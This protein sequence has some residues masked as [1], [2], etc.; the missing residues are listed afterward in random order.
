MF[1]GMRRK[2]GASNIA[3]GVDATTGKRRKI[4]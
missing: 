4:Q 1:D 2:E 3:A